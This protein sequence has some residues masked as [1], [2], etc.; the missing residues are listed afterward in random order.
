MWPES[1]RKYLLETFS[2]RLTEFILCVIRR[3]GAAWSWNSL[4]GTPIWYHAGSWR[5]SRPD[6]LMG[7]KDKPTFFAVCSSRETR[8]GGGGRFVERRVFVCF[9]LTSRRR[10]GLQGQRLNKSR[11]SDCGDTQHDVEAHR[12][13]I[14]V[15]PANLFGEVGT[16]RSMDYRYLYCVTPQPGC[17][18][19]CTVAQARVCHWQ[20]WYTCTLS[21]SSFQVSFI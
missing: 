2:R 8:R 13:Y 10:M 12:G 14:V 5:W 3:Q 6:S 20:W 7:A 16:R 4:G 9:H 17:C 15:H 11:R 1:C 21:R 18:T 19:A